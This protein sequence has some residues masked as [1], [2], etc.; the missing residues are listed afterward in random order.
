MHTFILLLLSVFAFH[1]PRYH[2]HALNGDDTYRSL[3]YENNKSFSSPFIIRRIHY[4]IPDLDYSSSGYPSE[5]F[6]HKKFGRS[7]IPIRIMHYQTPFRDG[8]PTNPMDAVSD[9]TR[10]DLD[11]EAHSGGLSILS[12]VIFLVLLGLSGAVGFYL[13]K[14]HESR[15][16]VRVPAIN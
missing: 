8:I 16:Y 5:Q 15:N 6:S 1:E 7:E 12:A 14:V 4:N 10:G 3:S 9:A 2:S 13:G 11:K